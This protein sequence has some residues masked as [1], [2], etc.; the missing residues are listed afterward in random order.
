M[1]RDEAIDAIKRI[2]IPTVGETTS[3]AAAVA[4]VLFDNAIATTS[5]ENGLT[6]EALGT[7]A[8]NLRERWGKGVL[9]DDDINT[10]LGLLRKRLPDFI[11]SEDLSLFSV[12][13]IALTKHRRSNGDRVTYLQVDYQPPAD[14]AAGALATAIDA[15]LPL[16]IERRTEVEQQLAAGKVQI[17]ISEPRSHPYGKGRIFVVFFLLLALSAFAVAL[18]KRFGILSEPLFPTTPPRVKVRAGA[19]AIGAPVTVSAPPLWALKRFR[20]GG[21]AIAG[22]SVGTHIYVA[23]GASGVRIF[24]ISNPENAHLARTIKTTYAYAVAIAEPYLYVADGDGGT[25]VVDLRKPAGAEIVATLPALALGVA[26]SGTHLFTANGAEGVRVWDVASPEHP[27]SLETIRQ[28]GNGAARNVAV[29]GSFAFVARAR[30][31]GVGAG[32]TILN[33]ADPRRVRVSSLISSVDDCHQVLALPDNVVLEV[34][35]R[36]IGTTRIYPSAPFAEG[37][38]LLSFSRPIR[39]VIPVSDDIVAAWID[40]EIVFVDVSNPKHLRVVP[41]PPID[42][43]VFA[44]AGLAYIPTH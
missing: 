17:H 20:T 11:R 16:S 37:L 42:P 6:R 22:T 44:K 40:D 25:R 32:T 4:T 10:Q 24:D 9:G 30:V 2:F 19:P 14:E 1:R 35:D 13:D 23:S 41:E 38:N 43:A 3:A 36:A 29:S 5:P 15:A 18:E 28:I 33:I 12:T 26:L 27:R 34:Y 8:S 21:P 31:L 7:A 39:A